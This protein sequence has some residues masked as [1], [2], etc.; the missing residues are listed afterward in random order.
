MAKIKDEFYAGVAEI[1]STFGRP[2]ASGT[3]ARA[4]P[5]WLVNLFP[6]WLLMQALA[7]VISTLKSLPQVQ[8][9][10]IKLRKTMLII[11]KAIQSVYDDDEEFV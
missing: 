9:A 4:L 2:T 6:D 7:I 1:E 3:G 10:K 8:A 5:G 11:F